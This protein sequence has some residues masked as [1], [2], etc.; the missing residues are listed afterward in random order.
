MVS[1][2]HNENK[3]VVSTLGV[4]FITAVII[5]AL[6]HFLKVSFGV[7]GFI[8]WIIVILGAVYFVLWA[9]SEIFNWS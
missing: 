8:A 3:I 9:L 4:I 7:L 5:A 1:L 2:I 6:Q